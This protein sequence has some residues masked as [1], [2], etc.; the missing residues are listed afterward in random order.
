MNVSLFQTPGGPRFL[1]FMLEFSQFVLLDRIH[2]M[3]RNLGDSCPVLAK[4]SDSGGAAVFRTMIRA[5]IENVAK[6]EKDLE[7]FKTE[8]KE[9]VDQSTERCR[10]LRSEISRV[11]TCYKEALS[12]AQEQRKKRNNPDVLE[13]NDDLEKECDVLKADTESLKNQANSYMLKNRESLA[14]MDSILGTSSGNILDMSNVSV[15][16]DT[17]V[18]V[19]EKLTGPVSDLKIP[20]QSFYPCRETESSQSKIAMHCQVM[21][22]R[23]MQ[24]RT[25]IL[26]NLKENIAELREKANFGLP[27]SERAATVAAGVTS[28]FTLTTNKAPGI[29]KL[30]LL[31]RRRSDE[32][33]SLKPSSEF[34]EDLD[35]NSL[36]METEPTSSSSAADRIESE[37]QFEFQLPTE[38][39]SLESRPSLDEQQGRRRLNS[40]ILSSQ[41]QHQRLSSI[42][43]DNTGYREPPSVIFPPH[44][45]QQQQHL[46]N[47]STSSNPHLSRSSMGNNSKLSVFSP[48]LSSS[49]MDSPGQQAPSFPSFSPPS[50]PNLEP[51]SES[52]APTTLPKKNLAEILPDLGDESNLGNS[53][54]LYQSHH[55]ERLGLGDDS[56]SSKPQ[57]ETTT[58]FR[59]DP[60]FLGDHSLTETTEPKKAVAENSNAVVFLET[61]C[62][63]WM[64]KT[65]APG[66]N[67]FKLSPSLLDRLE[68]DTAAARGGE[69]K[70]NNHDQKVS[71]RLD[72]LINTLALN[73]SELGAGN[74]SLLLS[75]E[76]TPL[77]L[78]IN[79]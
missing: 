61:G 21:A 64:R 56:F 71:N 55:H 63:D 3:K 73:N 26:P 67:V 62:T 35:N 31:P 28:R 68:K 65:N 39:D 52:P 78:D 70:E 25:N 74:D 32:P 75:T 18:G 11:D 42:H 69:G 9:F 51:I 76:N 17:V 46:S 5:N 72:D 15:H 60:T 43:N 57:L 7:E 66:N 50:G 24:L 27:Q 1:N 48:I 53:L 30:S 59:L 36:R 54:D 22:E 34:K 12:E 40:S 44:N 41:Q 4:P 37:F 47:M 49:R 16:G 38:K 33:D 23:Q 8:A 6:S 20:E 10:E 29:R 2:K 58:K 14:S 79:Y 77:D 19:L 45:Q 13:T